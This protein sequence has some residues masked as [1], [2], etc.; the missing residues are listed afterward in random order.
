MRIIDFRIPQEINEDLRFFK[1]AWVR[2][3]E[4]GYK[5]WLEVPHEDAIAE[6]MDPILD[7]RPDAQWRGVHGYFAWGI[8]GH[9]A[10]DGPGAAFENVNQRAMWLPAHFINMK[11][12]YFEVPTSPLHQ[13]PLT[14][15]INA[16]RIWVRWDVRLFAHF[17]TGKI[18][19]LL[20]ANKVTDPST[21]QV[22]KF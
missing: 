15:L 4:M 17:Q 14:A 19:S 10:D 9:T 7:I 16:V 22:Y 8:Y 20:G 11:D 3:K 12:N 1:Y 6:G 5:P 18:E 2:V 13:P 21:G